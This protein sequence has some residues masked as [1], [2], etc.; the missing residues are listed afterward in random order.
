LIDQPGIKGEEVEL[1][2]KL[3]SV[4]LFTKSTESSKLQEINPT[5]DAQNMPKNANNK[6]SSGFISFS[7]TLVSN[8]LY[9]RYLTD[10]LTLGIIY[11]KLR[12]ILLN[13]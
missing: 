11:K 9:I 10:L 5:F 8:M 4:C 6:I 2:R 3:V 12:N 13:Y 1:F 7:K